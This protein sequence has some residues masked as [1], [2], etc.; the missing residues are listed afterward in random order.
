[1]KFVTQELNTLVPYVYTACHLA[2]I[3][4]VVNS[5]DEERKV[6]NS[7]PVVQYNIYDVYLRKRRFS[8]CR[9]FI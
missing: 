3:G 1:M 7:K 8:V 6:S 5:S 9:N 2:R 4:V